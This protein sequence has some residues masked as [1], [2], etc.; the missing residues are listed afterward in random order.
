MSI[1]GMELTNGA[2]ARMEAPFA[3][4]P[5]CYAPK[6]G[7]A[8]TLSTEDIG[9]LGVALNE[10]TWLGV[11]LDQG[12]RAATIT[13]DCLTLPPEGAAP[14]DSEVRM[15]LHPVGRV[16]AVHYSADGDILP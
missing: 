8:V 13:L 15:V 2:A 10:A 16:H 4:H 3:A 12:R 1:K 14:E 11:A 5:Q 9:G 6:L 7:S